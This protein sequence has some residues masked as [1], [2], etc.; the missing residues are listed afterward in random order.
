MSS[1]AESGKAARPADPGQG[2]RAPGGALASGADRERMLVGGL[3]LVTALVYLR[4]LGNGFVFD[5]VELIVANRYMAQW[6][7]LWKSFAYDFFWIRDP[8]SLPQSLVYRPLTNVWLTIHRHLLIGPAGWHATLLMVHLLAVWLVFKVALRLAGDLWTA[9][10]AAALFALTPIHAEAVVWISAAA[11]PLS[12]VFELAAFY[13]FI[14]RTS[15]AQRHSPA[16]LLCYLAAVFSYDGAIIF[17]AL[18]GSYVLLLEPPRAETLAGDLRW[19]RLREAVLAATPFALEALLYLA[20]RRIVLGFFLSPFESMPYRADTQ[21]LLNATET[22]LTLP[23]VVADYAGLLIVPFFAG[24]SHRVLRVLSPASPEFY[25]PIVGLCLGVAILFALL[26]A[27]P[28]ARLYAFCAAWT[29]FAIVPMLNL[30]GIHPDLLVCDR[31][32][33]LASVGWSLLLAD[34]AV[35]LA[36]RSQPARSMVTVG[37]AAVLAGFSLSLWHV[38]GYWHDDVV[39]F[40]RCIDTFPESAICHGHMG[41]TL[42][43]RGDLAG[44]QVELKKAIDLDQMASAPELYALGQID[45]RQGQ[46]AAATTEIERSLSNMVGMLSHIQ[47]ASKKPKPAPA[48]AYALLAELYDQQ[49]Q[50]DKSR[51]V[52]SYTA[53]LPEGA[54][55]AGMAQSRID[56]R[57]GDKTSAEAILNDLARRF[58]ENPKI[59]VMLGLAM[60]DEGRNNE[61]FAAFEHALSIDPYDPQSLW[62]LAQALYAAGR[63]QEALHECELALRSSPDDPNLRALAAAIQRDLDRN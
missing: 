30:R 60:K 63:N 56:W 33:Y 49:G 26:R 46:T 45:A 29:G 58:P 2:A 22:I 50:A 44:A 14:T 35:N 38:Q 21:A 27:Q 34:W 36:R 62:F 32:L 53:S 57:H 39:L 15:P 41:L 59:W 54:E 3:L 19:P 48:L 18:L 47:T 10:L 11:L 20:V 61:A 28:R 9:L 12:T 25:L 23:H 8:F 4:S 24:P 7:F 5:D 6:S 51:A 31:Y 40:Q 13:L 17:P 37:A 55:A 16:A 42:K 52:L 43:Q 1:V